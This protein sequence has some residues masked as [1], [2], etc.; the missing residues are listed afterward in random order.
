[1]MVAIIVHKFADWVIIHHIE[2]QA[3]KDII[4]NYFIEE[5]VIVKSV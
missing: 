4:G 2:L 1:M 5:L 3:I